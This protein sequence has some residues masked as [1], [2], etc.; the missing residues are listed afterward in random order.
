M[1]QR[2]I[3]A[4]AQ[5]AWHCFQHHDFFTACTVFYAIQ[6]SAVFRM[7]KTR[8]G[9]KTGLTYAPGLGSHRCHICAG[10]GLSPLP[11][12]PRDWAH[13]ADICAAGC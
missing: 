4:C 6:C 3:C 12:L 8:A 9:L 5:W 2:A 7:Q 1:R 11:H 13:T 10:T